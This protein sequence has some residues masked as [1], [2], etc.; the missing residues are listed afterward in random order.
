MSVELSCLCATGT[1]CRWQGW[2]VSRIIASISRRGSFSLLSLSEGS[3]STGKPIMRIN[4]SFGFA[5][6]YV[7]GRSLSREVG[8]TGAAYSSRGRILGSKLQDRLRKSI[9]FFQSN[10]KQ[11]ISGHFLQLR[12]NCVGKKQYGNGQSTVIYSDDD[13]DDDET[14]WWNIYLIMIEKIQLISW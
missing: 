4:F 8:Q 3:A 11:E 7:Q 14:W 13:D 5:F 1:R 2:F 12:D 6:G 10:W 9:L